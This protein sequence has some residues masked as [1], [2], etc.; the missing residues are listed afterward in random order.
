MDWLGLSVSEIESSLRNAG[1]EEKKK[2]LEVLKFDD[3]KGVKN[4][5]S[6]IN[7]EIEKDNKEIERIERL[8][9]YEYLFFKKGAKYVAG[10]DEVGRGPLAGPVYACAAIFPIDCMIK[11]IDDSKKLTPEKRE[12]LSREI[13]E[14]AICYSIGCSDE[15]TIDRVNILNATYMAMKE[16]ISKLKIKPQ[17]LLI[18]AVRIPG[19]DIFQYPIIK[20]DSLSFSIAGAS[21]LAKVERD[22][23][24]DN[25]HEKYEAYNFKSN[26]GYGTKEHIEAIRNFGPC[27]IH[28]RT[29]ISSFI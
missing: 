21:I 5:V 17:A 3:R 22:S 12:V 29:F 26:K 6:R 13:K 14:R 25:Y 1:L 15:K 8:K 20:G 7:N 9:Q 10:I 2:I 16:A 4:I 24:M 27:P 28:R 11:G 18:D 19:I 23:V